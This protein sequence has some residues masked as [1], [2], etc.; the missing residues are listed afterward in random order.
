L[1]VFTSDANL[2]GTWGEELIARVLLSVGK[3]CS[4]ARSRASNAIMNFSANM[5]ELLVQLLRCARFV[6][7]L[8]Q[9]SSKVLMSVQDLCK[10]GLDR[11]LIDQVQ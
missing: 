1:L 10:T 3:D 4:W 8:F 9:R 6:T 2:T 11:Q 7:V 5:I